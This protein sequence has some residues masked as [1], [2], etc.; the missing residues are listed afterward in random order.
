M[1]HLPRG[2]VKQYKFHEGGFA[3]ELAQGLSFPLPPSL[4]PSSLTHTQRTNPGWIPLMLPMGL[5]DTLTS[6]LDLPTFYHT[7]RITGTSFR[8]SFECECETG[9]RRV[10][11]LTL[12][13]GSCPCAKL[14]RRWGTCFAARFRREGRKS[15]RRARGLRIRTS[16]G[17]ALAGIDAAYARERAATRTSLLTSRR[18]LARRR[19]RGFRGLDA[20]LDDIG[21]E[22]Q[23]RE[24]KKKNRRKALG[25]G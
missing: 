3:L 8:L 21:T 7:V 1:H 13:S 12:L 2:N 6:T 9:G 20:M 15:P 16:N 23:I 10:G 24:C 18:S 5:A 22:V 19:Q 17:S 25:S 14:A 4:N 11:R